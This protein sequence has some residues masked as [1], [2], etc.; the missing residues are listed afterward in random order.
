MAAIPTW[1]P[2]SM[3][4]MWM[5]LLPHS[6]LDQAEPALLPKGLGLLV[7]LPCMPCSN[8]MH[9]MG[10]LL[11]EALVKLSTDCSQLSTVGS[12]QQ[13][14]ALH[15]ACWQLTHRLPLV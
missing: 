13:L 10:P 2:W 12:G 4:P 9:A 15:V 14:T 8:Y 5:A 7:A 6:P 11:G 3:M 1:M